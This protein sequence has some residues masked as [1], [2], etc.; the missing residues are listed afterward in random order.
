M[1]QADDVFL[2]NFLMI[3]GALVLFTVIVFFVGRTIGARTMEEMQFAPSA[4]R[5][6][7]APVGQVR[8]GEPGTQVAVVVEE[9]S[10]TA[11]AAGPRS[12]EEVYGAACSACHMAGVAGAPKTG[13]KEVWGPRF[14]QGIDTL[15]ASALNGKGAMPPKG[16]QAALSEEEVKGAVEYILAQA[17]FSVGSGAASAAA[18]AEPARAASESSDSAT[19]PAGAAEGQASAAEQE[20][21]PAAESETAELAA[22][23][24]GEAGASEQE[25]AAATE[26]EPAEPETVAAAESA[27]AGKSGEEVYQSACV[28]CHAAGVAGAPKTGDKESWGARADQGLAALVNSAVN[29]KGAMPAKGGQPALTDQE[30]QGAIQYMLEQTGLTAN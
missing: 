26:S 1:S 16:G 25:T 4:V 10:A 11:P 12:G 5:E 23:A 15:Y 3:L 30:V 14:E 22:G 28:V 19:E 8:V 18:A 24:K 9:Q 27:P 13:D 29:G 2:K 20:T 17:G 6:R 7:I 21:A